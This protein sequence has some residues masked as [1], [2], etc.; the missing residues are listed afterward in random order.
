MKIVITH[1]YVCIYI[2]IERERGRII[3]M[4]V[5]I[6]IILQASPLDAYLAAAGVH[7]AGELDDQGLAWLASRFKTGAS[8]C[9]C[10]VLSCW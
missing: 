6:I 8:L 2:Y 10:V 5:I 7:V 4:L 1:M 9:F 3:R